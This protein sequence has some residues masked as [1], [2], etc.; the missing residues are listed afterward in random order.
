MKKLNRKQA[1]NIILY[2]IFVVLLLLLSFFSYKLFLFNKKRL[3]LKNQADLL[4]KE[5]MF[6]VQENEMLNNS[7]QE[8]LTNE[9]FEKEARIMLGLKQEGES[10]VILNKDEVVLNEQQDQDK[11]IFN[12]F[13]DFLKNIFK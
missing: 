6:M 5:A 9:A 7:N 12:N 10:V 2:S 8:F 13:F 3:A 4:E 11:N 1:N